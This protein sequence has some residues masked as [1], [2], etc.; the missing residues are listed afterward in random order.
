MFQELTE[1]TNTQGHY[2]IDAISVLTTLSILMVFSIVVMTMAFSKKRKKPSLL[3]ASLLSVS[4]VG[5]TFISIMLVQMFTVHAHKVTQ[6]SS[7]VQ[8]FNAGTVTQTALHRDPDGE[9]E[10]LDLTVDNGSEGT[11][12]MIT[13]PVQKY[14]LVGTGESKKSMDVDTYRDFLNGRSVTMECTDLER[15]DT[16]KLTHCTVDNID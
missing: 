4:L 8:L 11:P 1:T 13:V 3:R 12:N 16:G 6:E 7:S 9:P 10:S 14:T 5:T 15:D 2:I